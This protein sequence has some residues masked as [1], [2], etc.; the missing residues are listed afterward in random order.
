MFNSEAV[1]TIPP[2]TSNTTTLVSVLQTDTVSCEILRFFLENENAMDSAKGIAAWW[3]HR[4]ELAVQPS[5][6]RLLSCGAVI[7]HT[8]T[9]GVTLYKLTHDRALRTWL[10]H[11][12]G[13]SGEPHL[14]DETVDTPTEPVTDASVS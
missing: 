9:S 5:L 6:H 3:I 8:L 10:H 12:L 4:D 14:N 2:K 13:V 11:V 1:T 7:A